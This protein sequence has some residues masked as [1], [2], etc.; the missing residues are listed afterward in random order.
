MLLFFGRDFPELARDVFFYQISE[1][2]PRLSKNSCQKITALNNPQNECVGWF[3]VFLDLLAYL[4][5]WP[6]LN[7]WLILTYS[8][9]NNHSSAVIFLN[10]PW[11]V[12]KNKGMVFRKY[13]YLLRFVICLKMQL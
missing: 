7:Y 2:Y 12:K 6:I 9:Q 3:T 4:T 5:Y 1:D 10:F 13:Q 8:S 11:A